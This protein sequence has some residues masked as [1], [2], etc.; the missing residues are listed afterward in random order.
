MKKNSLLYL[1]NTI[2]VYNIVQFCL[3]YFDTVGRKSEEHAACKQFSDGM[4]ICL[5]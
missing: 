2:T 1:T 3:Q 5:E 4:V